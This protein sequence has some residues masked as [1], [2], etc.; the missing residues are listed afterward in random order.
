MVSTEG[1]Y[2][3]DLFAFFG[4]L[5]VG[6]PMTPSFPIFT[7]GGWVRLHLSVISGCYLSTEIHIGG[8][9]ATGPAPIFSRF[10]PEAAVPRSRCVTPFD[11]GDP[12]VHHPLDT[13][14]NEWRS[15]D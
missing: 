4:F 1:A 9:A 11:L 12:C 14:C 15:T 13:G 2:E 6:S 5:S 7:E 3:R 10:R 8:D